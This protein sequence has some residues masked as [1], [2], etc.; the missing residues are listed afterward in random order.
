M[1]FHYR[2]KVSLHDK[3][4]MEKGNRQCELKK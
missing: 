4:H 3:D 2:E 1:N